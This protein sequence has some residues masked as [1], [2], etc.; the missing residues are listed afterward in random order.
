M[1]AATCA[2]TI[3]S[4]KYN[5]RFLPAI[6]N[7]RLRRVAGLASFVGCLLWIRFVLFHLPMGATN[8]VFLLMSLFGLEWTMIAVLGGV[9]HGL[10]K[11][12]RRQTTL[13]D[14]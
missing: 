12:A 14:T 10:E 6:R 13:V 4:W 8:N 2:L 11:A 3:L 9:A 5:H 7:Q 1:L